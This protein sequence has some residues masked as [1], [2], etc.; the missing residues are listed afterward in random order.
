MKKITLFLLT[1]CNL[2]FYSQT[3]RISDIEKAAEQPPV[4][5][6]T[7][8]KPYATL[9]AYN[10]A[11]NAQNLIEPLL[12]GQFPLIT[13]N[14]ITS[15]QFEA[16]NTQYSSNAADDFTVPAGK[17]WQVST[18]FVRG[19]SAS[20]VYPTS[21]KITFYTNTA[22]N[23]P[24]TIIRTENVIL[25]AGSM[26]PTLPLAS[27]LTLAAGKYWVSVQAVLD[28]VGGGQW[29]W[30]T[31][32]AST[33]LGSP[34]AWTNPG[35]GFGTP[36]NT[37]WNSGSV[38][39]PSQ[40]KD[41]QFSLD[42]TESNVAAAAC[43]TFVSRI[44][45]TDATENTRLFRDANPSV[46]GTT[47]PYPSPAVAGAFHYKSYTIQNTMSS[48]NCVTVN[49]TN[50]DPTYQ[51]HLVAYTGNFNPANIALNYMGDSGSS[52]VGSTVAT[53]NLTMP[54]NSTM[55]IVVN[56][57]TAN[58]TFS[59]DYSLDI[60]SSNCGGILK[61]AESG[62]KSISIYPNPVKTVLFVNGMKANEAKIY[63]SSGKLV[64]VQTSEN[65]INVEGLPK[66]NYL[67]QMNDKNG[68]KM[69]TKFIKK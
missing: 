55:V 8:S 66:G 59:A 54:A 42:G 12:Y 43:K 67:L 19:S 3:N 17:L 52:S 40:L 60:F 36:C 18:V 16:A 63:D 37:V 11:F 4:V 58:S 38:C 65:Q 30:E 64:P 57:T 27:P 32:T 31:Y 21:Y 29:Y 9:A 35:N 10:A 24:G 56:E 61:T 14:T 44:I 20:P 23:L 26:S 1:T 46:C 41:L 2:L 47:K 7:P 39:I 53:M 68:N 13:T 6:S 48:T 62:G 25:A 69:T 45:N 5:Y 49:L 33:T 28:F 22:A 50:L 34:Y 51:L 15:Q